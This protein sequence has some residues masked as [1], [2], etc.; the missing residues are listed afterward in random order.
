[1][2]P[3]FDN[4]AAADERAAYHRRNSAE[5]RRSFAARKIPRRISPEEWELSRVRGKSYCVADRQ[6]DT[7]PGEFGVSER[8]FLCAEPAV[9]DFVRARGANVNVNCSGSSSESTFSFSQLSRTGIPT[10]RHRHSSCVKRTRDFSTLEP[11]V[12]PR[13][14]S[15]G[16]SVKWYRSE[17]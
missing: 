8:A 16:N 15:S 12:T 5:I 7:L 1:M 3:E 13:E 4:K 10:C 6:I 2:L 11:L 14:R 9:V 17:N